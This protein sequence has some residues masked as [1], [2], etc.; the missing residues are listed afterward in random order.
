VGKER[1]AWGPNR[2]RIAAEGG[3]VEASAVSNGSVGSTVVVVLAGELWR[4]MDDGGRR[5][6]VERMLISNHFIL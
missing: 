1:R 5:C 6:G 4:L 3:R 2:H